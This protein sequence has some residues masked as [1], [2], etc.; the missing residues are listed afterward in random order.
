[1]SK[2]KNIIR[3]G[4]RVNLYK[5]DVDGYDSWWSKAKV[6]G[7]VFISDDD[8]YK[9]IEIEGCNLKKMS[10]EEEQKELNRDLELQHD[11]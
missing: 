6:A 9:N 2:R 7:V 8:E 5:L 3:V 10:Q 4:D 1:M 11:Y